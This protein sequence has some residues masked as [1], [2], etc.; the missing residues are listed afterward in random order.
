MALMAGGGI[1]AGQV[2]GA[3]D[4]IASEATRRP[5]H[6]QDVFATL[7]RNLGIPADRTTIVDPSGGLQYLLDRGRVI[8]PL[9]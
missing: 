5:V 8:E 4:R 9:V 2:I 1:R 6:Y 3:T 7:Y